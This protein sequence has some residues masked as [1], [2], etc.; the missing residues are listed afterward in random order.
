MDAY[1][2]ERFC[3]RWI[4]KALS[5]QSNEL[6]DL[7]DRFFTLFVAY[8]RIYSAVSLSRAALHETASGATA[9]RD[10]V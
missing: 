3:N 7:F 8:N 1:A 4:E 10:G 5:Y 9:E 2:I 6:E